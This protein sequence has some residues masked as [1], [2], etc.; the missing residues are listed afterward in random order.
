W[1]SA[2]ARRHQGARTSQ[3]HMYIGND[4]I[5]HLDIVVL[6]GVKDKDPV[7]R[8]PRPVLDGI[9]ADQVAHTGAIVVSMN[10]AFTLAYRVVCIGSAFGPVGHNSIISVSHHI[11]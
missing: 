5:C 3:A 2:T 1:R 7:T 8:T 9:S 10:T 4:I 11:V 6:V